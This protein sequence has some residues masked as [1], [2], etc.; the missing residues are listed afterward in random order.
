[1]TDEMS[2]LFPNCLLRSLH[3]RIYRE[4]CAGIKLAGIESDEM[5][6]RHTIVCSQVEWQTMKA[7]MKSSLSIVNAATIRDPSTLLIQL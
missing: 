2:F 4:T 1:M 6:A 5:N 7:D 3:Q